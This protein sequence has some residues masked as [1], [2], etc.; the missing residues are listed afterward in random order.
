MFPKLNGLHRLPEWTN[1]VYPSDELDEIALLP[2]YIYA[3][4]PDLAKIFSGFLLKEIFDRSANKSAGTLSPD[5]N[6]WVYS[7][8]DNVLESLLYT[9]GV[10]DVIF[11]SFLKQLLCIN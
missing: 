9:L 2:Y 11:Y 8:H 7:S 1:S 4:T 5:R 3:Y 6:V 10:F